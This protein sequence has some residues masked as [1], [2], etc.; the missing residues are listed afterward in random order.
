[1]TQ[2]TKNI[3]RWIT[4]PIAT[5]ITFLAVIGFVGWIYSLLPNNTDYSRVGYTAGIL[6]DVFMA[7]FLGWITSL[8]AI[9]YLT[10]KIAP[11]AKKK[12]AW[13][14][15][16]IFASPIVLILIAGIIEQIAD[17]KFWK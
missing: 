16:I 14:N 15:T 11:K 10:F 2:K 4:L 7:I 12:A 1:M 13:I 17:P 6:A 5:I 3:F 9:W 8:P